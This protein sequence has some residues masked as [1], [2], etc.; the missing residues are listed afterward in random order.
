MR[1]RL[2]A[3]TLAAFSTVAPAMGDPQASAQAGADPKA[4][5]APA[6]PAPAP[7]WTLGGQV[8]ADYYVVLAHDGPAPADPGGEDLKGREGFWL[9]RVYLTY[10]QRFTGRLSARLRLEANSAGDFV[11]ATRLEPF[12]KDA[13][14]QVRA[15]GHTVALGLVPTVSLRLAER[16]WGLR[17]VEKTPL[18][19]YRLDSSRD[20]GVTASGRAGPGQRLRY[21]AQVG[22]GAGVSSETNDAKTVRG[23]L[24]W[25]AARGAVAQ[26]Y[27]DHQART[28]AGDWTTIVAMAGWHEARWRTA[29]LYAFQRRRAPRDGEHGLDLDLLSVFAVADLHPRVAIFGRVDRLF[30]PLPG[31][32]TIEYLPLAGEVAP[33]VAIAGADVAVEGPL[34]LQPHVQVVDYGGSAG[35]SPTVIPRVTL[36]LSW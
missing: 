6:Q 25:E 36:S 16:V 28:G 18:D 5:P 19:L 1:S 14:V 17:S 12:F 22:N 15:G 11:S 21:E 9:R 24:S 34:R 23:A 8:F 35:R 20:V 29:A 10:D 31:A 13:Y 3:L 32:F 27:V 7:A 33:T 4:D 26:G 2:A 30:D